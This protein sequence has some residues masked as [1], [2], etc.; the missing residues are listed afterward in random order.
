MS[1]VFASPVFIFCVCALAY[2]VLSNVI[3][4]WR[5][6]RNHERISPDYKLLRGPGESLRRQI[7]EIDDRLFTSLL[8]IIIPPLAFLTTLVI[9]SL[10]SEKAEY[11]KFFGLMVQLMIPLA[12]AWI[13]FVAW[14]LLRLLSKRRNL[15]LGYFGERVVS[16]SLDAL[17]A[18]GARVFHDVP[19]ASDA[20]SVNIDHVVVCPGGVFAIETK[21]RRKGRVR[22]GY[23]DGKVTFDGAQ[24]I[25]PWGEDTF[26]LQQAQRNALW[27]GEFIVSQLVVQDTPVRAILTFPGW[28]VEQAANAAENPV[29]VLSPGQIAAHIEAQKPALDDAQ[30]GI[31]AR[32]LEMLCRDVEF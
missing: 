5:E 26:G 14:R 29:R 25:Y 15:Y 23:T 3:W 2:V 31:I 17:R 19:V 7:A 4:R 1:D 6:N 22:P 21:T 11:E 32:R 12:L 10:L 18:K 9:V 27:F 20:G 8:T 13:V 30:I 28:R 24:L 16:E